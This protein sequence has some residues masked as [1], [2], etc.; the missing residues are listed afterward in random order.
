R[1]PPLVL[2]GQLRQPR[3]ETAPPGLT[4][5]GYSVR[6]AGRL[7]LPRPDEAAAV[8][9]VKAAWELDRVAAGE[10]L[11]AVAWVAAAA[12]TR[13]GDWLVVGRDEDGDAKWSHQATAFYVELAPFV[14]AGTVHFEGE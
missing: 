3:Q 5:M 2:D 8:A 9:A 11:S 1:P 6:S 10:T 7:H 14:R 13:D 12:I 4:T